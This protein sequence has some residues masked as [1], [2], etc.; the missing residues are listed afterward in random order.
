MRTVSL[1]FHDV[2]AA[3]PRESGFGSPGADRYKLSLRQFDAQL[4][5]LAKVRADAPVLMQDSSGGLKP[6]INCV[7]A[8]E[9]LW[10]SGRQGSP[11]RARRLTGSGQCRRGTQW[12]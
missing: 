5:G 3:D 2:Y 10:R 12:G 1:L 8:D 7:D 9:A 11:D 4:D 6:A